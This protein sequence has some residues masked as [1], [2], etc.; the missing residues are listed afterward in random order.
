MID[1]DDD[2]WIIGGEGG[3]D[4]AK[5]GIL[6]AR[7]HEA[8]GRRIFR[9]PRLLRRADLQQ[10]STWLRGRALRKVRGVDIGYVRDFVDDLWR[11]ADRAALDGTPHGGRGSLA[12]CRGW[13]Q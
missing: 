7:P 9:R 1:L 13:P 5:L 10:P 12:S 8:E 3:E 4:A 11:R 6:V 2:L